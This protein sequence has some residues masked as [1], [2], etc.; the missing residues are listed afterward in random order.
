MDNEVFGGDDNR[1]LI[2]NGFY[3]TNDFQN[4]SRHEKNKFAELLKKGK[5]Y[6]DGG[7]KILALDCYIDCL[8]ISDENYEIHR[9]VLKLADETGMLNEL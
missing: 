3:K 7:E 4:L 2:K 8:N 6:E 9:N 1:I 5:Q